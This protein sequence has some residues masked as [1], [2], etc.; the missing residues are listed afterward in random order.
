MKIDI[1]KFNDNFLDKNNKFID[2]WQ[3]CIKILPIASNT[4]SSFNKKCGLLGFTGAFFRNL[5]NDTGDGI[6]DFDKFTED[7]RSTLSNIKSMQPNQIDEFIEIFKDIFYINGNLNIPDSSFLKY[8]PLVPNDENI[9]QKQ[10]RYFKDGTKKVADYV[11]SMLLTKDVSQIQDSKTNIFSDIIHSALIS[12]RPI[13]NSNLDNNK[14]Y[15]LPYIRESFQKDFEWMINQEE[16]VKIKYFP[17]FLYFYTCYSLTQSIIN[18]SPK[19][20]E[21]ISHPDPF[22]FILKSEKASTNHDAVI[23]GWDNKIPTQTLNKLLGKAQALNIANI[24]LE[25]NNTPIGF[26]PEILSKLQHTPFEENKETCEQILKEY[27]SGK[28][29]TFKHRVSERSTYDEDR[30][31]S[32][33]SYQDFLNQLD[34]ICTEFISNSSLILSV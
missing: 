33:S 2:N 6:N 32:V 9:S 23:N 7:V 21:N 1:S 12:Y 29:K 20:T 27:I 34:S 5:S 26:Y 10:Y 16:S 22:Y 15:I 13:N 28:I 17:L 31:I 8:L 14:Y 4:A 11:S 18:I 3:G 25:E 24:L 30:N 19:R